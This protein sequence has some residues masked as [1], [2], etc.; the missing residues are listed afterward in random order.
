MKPMLYIPAIQR[1]L[2]VNLSKS[3]INKL[4]KIL[5]LAYS[6]Q[7][8]N[9]A[10]SIKKQLEANKIKIEKFQQVLGCSKIKT[11]FSVLLISTGKFHAQ[12]LFLQTPI[13][14]TLENDKIVQIS[15]KEIERIKVHR[16]TALMKF[17]RADRIGI[18]VSTKPGQEK[19]SEAV[20]LKNNLEKRGRQAYIFIS[21]NIDINQLENFP[22]DSWVNTACPG[23]SMDNPNIINLSELPNQ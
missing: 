15:E 13:L 18:L 23:L 9:L 1:N 19:L 4:P 20:K 14:Y 12:N 6:I 21:D 16:K 7:Y 10:E 11:N 22:V 17:L 2:D 3:E 8:K 5:L